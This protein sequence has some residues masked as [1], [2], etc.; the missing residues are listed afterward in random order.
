MGSASGWP[1]NFIRTL[2]SRASQR[3]YPSICCSF[4]EAVSILKL[5]MTHLRTLSWIAS[6][7][8]SLC[9]HAF[10]V[11]LALSFD[12]WF[13][14][15]VFAASATCLV[16]RKGLLGAALL[17]LAPALSCGPLAIACA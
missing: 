15:A 11:T 14:R 9:A 10:G 2:R 6:S 7:V 1:S 3:L 8:V 13:W 16:L 17:T 12:S 5:L 4:W